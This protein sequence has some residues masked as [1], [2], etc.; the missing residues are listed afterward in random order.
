[1]KA[2]GDI[3]PCEIIPLDSVG[4]GITLI[5]GYCAGDSFSWIE[6]QTSGPS[7]GVEGQNSLAGDVEGGDVEGFE[8]NLC[9]FLSVIFRVFGSCVVEGL[10]SVRRQGCYSGVFLS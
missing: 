5:D 7:C 4:K 6:D 3:L 1:M 2:V 8:H 9:H 10:L